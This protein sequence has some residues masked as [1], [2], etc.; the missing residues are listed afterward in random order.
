LGLTKEVSLRIVRFKADNRPRYGLVEGNSVHSLKISPF[1]QRGSIKFQPSLDGNEYTLDKVK[2]L[3]PSVPSKVI[4]LGVN[5]RSHAIETGLAIPTVPLIFLKPPTAVIGPED[6]IELPRLEKRRVDYE[7]ELG[8][9]IG[10]RT[11]GISRERANDCVL[12]YTCFNDVSERYAQK[13]DGQWTRCKGYDTF[14]PIGPWIDTEVDPDDLK[15]ESYLNGEV[16]QSARTSD[17]IFGVA[18]I[19][20]FISGIMT[21]LPGDVIATGT[22]SGIGKMHPGDVIE[23]KIEKI[24]TLKNYVV[25]HE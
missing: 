18:E 10:T 8:V 12:G 24:G 5:Y 4:C 19:V 1:A 13:F 3:A 7:A 17:L 9:V 20:S 6:K 25:D 16:R 22:P 2:L 23:I 15:V 11:K 14:A 21:L